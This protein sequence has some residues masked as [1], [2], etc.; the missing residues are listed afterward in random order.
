MRQL[1]PAFSDERKQAA[2]GRWVIYYGPVLGALVYA[3]L[4]LPA[5]LTNDL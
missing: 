2:S 5:V 4:N 1:K 3:P